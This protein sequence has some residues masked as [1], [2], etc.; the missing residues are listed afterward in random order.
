MNLLEELKKLPES[1]H[2]QEVF[3]RVKHFTGNIKHID[4]VTTEIF[5]FSV[6]HNL[7]NLN[8]NDFY[9]VVNLR[10]IDFV[11]NSY[12]DLLSNDYDDESE[13]G[14]YAEQ[15]SLLNVGK[16]IKLLELS[17]N[18]NVPV[19]AYSFMFNNNADFLEITKMEKDQSSSFG[20]LSDCYILS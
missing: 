6:T 9:Q 17:I 20:H 13:E 8:T 16:L 12:A 18:P 14:G 2:E 5:K 11:D 1:T 3:F 10:S 19:L 4:S 15:S 7:P